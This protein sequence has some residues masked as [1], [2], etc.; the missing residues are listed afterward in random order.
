MIK[1]A[2]IVLSLLFILTPAVK[3]DSLY[4]KMYEALP[5]TEGFTGDELLEKYGLNIKNED[6]IKNLNL[7][8]IFSIFKELVV[9]GYKAPLLA[10]LSVLAATI[11]AAAFAPFLQ[12]NEHFLSFLVITAAAFVLLPLFNSL[13]VA[14]TALKTV[15]NFMLTFIPIFIG[16]VISSGFVGAGSASSPLLLFVATIVSKISTDTF[17]P[18]M[19]GYLSLSITGGIS[20]A[21]S[22]KNLASSIKNAANFIMGLCTTIFLGVLSISGNVSAAGDSLAMKTT[23]F[24]V[25]GVPVVGGA[26]AESIGAA[27]AATELL[28]TGVGTFGMVAVA[29]ILLPVLVNLLLW[30]ASLTLSAFASEILDVKS[31]A[32]FF[33]SVT[34]VISV[35]IGIIIFVGILFIIGLAIIVGLRK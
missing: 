5:Q 13:T 31:L 26:I 32:D 4:S 24:L 14:A 15:A 30:K 35:T 16:V 23:R 29:I 22:L 28:K 18:L 25:S 8:N 21:F 6:W 10:F 9:N 3:A 7:T 19:G 20:P 1:K 17:L 34:A 2:V 11:I 12:E 27:T 33:K